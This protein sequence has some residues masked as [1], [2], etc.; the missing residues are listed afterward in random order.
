[1]IRIPG[2]ATTVEMTTAGRGV[3]LHRI[4]DFAIVRAVGAEGL[5]MTYDLPRD[6]FVE[7]TNG[8]DY[9]FEMRGDEVTSIA[10]WDDFYPFYLSG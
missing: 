4:G 8:V 10:P 3:P 1:M 7:R 2:F 5:T 9:T 6:S